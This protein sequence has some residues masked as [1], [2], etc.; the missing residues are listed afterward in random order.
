VTIASPAVFTKSSHGFVGNGREELTLSTTGALPTGLNT[1]AKYYVMATGL[2]TNTF[3]VSLTPGG[4]TAVNTS[5]SQSGTHTYSVTTYSGEI[6]VPVVPPVTRPL[7]LDTVI[8]ID[9]AVYEVVNGMVNATIEWTQPTQSNYAGIDFWYKRSISTDTVYRTATNTNRPGVGSTITHKFESLYRSAV[10]Y[11][12]ICRVKFTSGESS[13]F[14]TKL[15]LA[16]SGAISTENPPE[17]FEQVSPG[18]SPNTTPLPNQRDTI[19][20]SKAVGTTVFAS[21]GVPATPRS[22]TFAVVQDVT[23]RGLNTEVGGVNIYYKLTSASTWSKVSQA[24]DAAYVP[25]QTVTFTF[26]GDLG[27]RTYPAS[28]NASDNFDFI[29]RFAYKDA[30]ESRFQLRYMGVDVERTTAV[31]FVDVLPAAQGQELASAYS[32]TLADPALQT[33][34][35]LITITPTI[36]ANS[37][38]NPSRILISF[39]P[40]NTTNQQQF[41]GVRLYYRR[42]TVGTAPAFTVL[43]ITEVEQ[44][45]ASEWRINLAIDYDVEYQYV[46]VPLVRYPSGTLNKVNGSSAWIGQGAIHNRQTASDYPSTGNWFSRLNFRAIESNTIAGIEATPF[47]QTN[48]YVFV[49]GWKLIQTN[50]GTANSTANFHYYEL[51]FDKA[52]VANYD[53]LYVY[54]RTADYAVGAAMATKYYGLGRFERVAVVSATNATTLANGNILVNL[55]IPTNFAEYNPY[56]PASATPTTTT[57]GQTFIQ[58][59]MATNVWGANSTAFNNEFYLVVSSGATPA[60]SPVATKLPVI[61]GIALQGEVASVET[62]TQVNVSDYN[63]TISGWQRRMSEYRASLANANYKP[64]G[65]AYTAPTVRRGSAVT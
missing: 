43:D 35:R 23:Q 62:P 5:G 53:R 25:G 51:E 14:T 6:I 7:P 2:T 18:W 11:E 28:D 58:G 48:P 65:S 19:F 55:R 32:I 22:V 21:A 45:S 4:A 61:K 59:Y 57:S 30:T 37:L 38:S 50:N 46:L 3:R 60:E 41:W 17:F 13:T 29:F 42:V 8:R 47:T 15:T 64:G 44:L 63:T 40:P 49:K 56:Y 33:D 20:A 9:R 36:A 54:R 1:T 10:P 27:L 52:H 16:V 34:T 12:L 24:F 31:D 39:T 26:P